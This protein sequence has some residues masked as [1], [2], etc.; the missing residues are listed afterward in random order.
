MIKFLE[1]IRY[2]RLFLRRVINDQDQIIVR[3]SFEC[4]LGPEHDVRKYTGQIGFFDKNGF[5]DLAW[6]CRND[7]NIWTEWFVDT[8]VNPHVVRRDYYHDGQR[9]WNMRKVPMSTTSIRYI[10]EL[11][12]ELWTMHKMSI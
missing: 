3:D 12:H 1:D 2:D 5:F 10:N 7:G 9:Q 11:S 6:M 8:E 4:L